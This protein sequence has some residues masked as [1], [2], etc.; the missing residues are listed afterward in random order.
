MKK[1]FLCML[2]VFMFIPAIFMFAG[3]KDDGYKLTN[4]NV[5][6]NN[7]ANNC[8]NIKIVENKIVF[9]YES[10]TIGSTKF[11]SATI[12]SVEPY[13]N[14]KNYNVLLDNLMGFVY[15]Y[16]D[17]CSNKNIEASDEVRNN[18]KANLDQLGETLYDIDVYIGQWAEVV[19]FNYTEDVTNSQCLSR[20]KTLLI[21]Y[22]SLF[23]KAINFSNSLASLYYNNA[24][25]DANPRID[26]IALVDFDSSI[27]ISKLE[28]RVKYEISNLS[29]LF[30]E[31][32]V[33]GNDL[34]TQLT[35]PIIV[36]EGE[37]NEYVVFNT[38]SLNQ[39]GFNYQTKVN[40]LNRMTKEKV[41]AGKQCAI[42]KAIE[43][44][45]TDDEKDVARRAR[46]TAK[47]QIAKNYSQTEYNY[48]TAFEAVIGYLYL[49]KQEQRLNEILNFSIMEK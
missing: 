15:K 7:I 26:N 28:S 11:L 48:A 37:D 14:L 6:Y 32:Y 27:I 39:T 42:F 41:N 30:V 2:L 23:Q 24:L 10:Y 29:Q 18:L 36:N 12:N 13:T 47:G 45:L 44:S 31:I 25:N 33:D 19:E 34:P 38:F 43:E 8:E 4:L 9:D 22:N 35:T 21:G 49:T 16:I 40:S 17:V 20:F 3:C 5:D 1:K 46:N